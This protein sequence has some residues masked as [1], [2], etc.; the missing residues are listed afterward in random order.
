VTLT[1]SNI[2]DEIPSTPTNPVTQQVTFYY[3]SS[4]GTK[5][6]LGTVTVSSS[7]TW[8]LSSPTAF[9]LAA[10]TYTLYAQAED[11]YGVFGDLAALTL[12]V[13]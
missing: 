11:S 4:S 3:N 7:G 5:V 6:T 8:T 12:T 10:G 1:A 2:S 9:G 13:Q